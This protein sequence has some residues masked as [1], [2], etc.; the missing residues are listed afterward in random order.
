MSEEIVQKEL[1]D[2]IEFEWRKY[3]MYLRLCSNMDVVSRAKEIYYKTLIHDQII[4]DI[5]N[6]KLTDSDM[7]YYLATSDLI[8]TFYVKMQDK[9]CTIS[10]TK[11]VIDDRSWGILLSAVKF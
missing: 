4:N 3:L 7:R 9:F 2:K 8:D 11:D 6:G 1:I 10:I 5:E